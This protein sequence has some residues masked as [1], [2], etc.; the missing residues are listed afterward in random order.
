M[1]V[2]RVLFDPDNTLWCITVAGLY[3]APTSPVDKLDFELV[4]PGGNLEWKPAAFADSR[5]WLWFGLP[6]ELVEIVSGDVLRY[7]LPDPNGSFLINAMAEDSKGRL[8][9]VNLGELFEFIEPADP[10]QPGSWKKLH[11]S[12]SPKQFSHHLL[13]TQRTRSGSAH[14]E[15]L[16]NTRKAIRSCI[17][18]RRA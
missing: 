1:E 3:R 5:G 8:V 13:S 10:K 2:E 12:L 14:N 7:R 11:L 17:P 15:A 4:A 18:R 16:S 6:N 9:A